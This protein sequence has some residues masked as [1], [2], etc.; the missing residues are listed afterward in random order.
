MK[1]VV[2]ADEDSRKEFNAKITG[3]DTKVTYIKGLREIITND[4]D[5]S[6][7]DAF[8]IL[9]EGINNQD[10]TIF[11]RKPVFINSVT[12][13]LKA[14]E[15]PENFYRFNGWP[16]F[17]SREIWE[18]AGEEKNV[19]NIFE[20]LQ[21]KYISVA[22]EP[23]LI[24]AR[25][26]AMIINEAYFALGE[27]VSSKDEIDIAMKL[28]TNYPYGPFEWGKKIGLQKVYD[29]LRKLNETESRYSIAPA[30]KNELINF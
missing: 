6:S 25:I 16:G 20:N 12:N 15:L 1:I 11:K 4:I 2:L 19:E 29:L 13:T 18:I 26:I 24:S 10:H 28:G 3:A 17:I 21:W 30:M 9:K 5:H 7:A 14:L 8:I 23:G 27:D 22:D